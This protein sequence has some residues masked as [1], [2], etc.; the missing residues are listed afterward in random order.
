MGLEARV[1]RRRGGDLEAEV[2]GVRCLVVREEP[3][4]GETI[5]GRQR[6]R[7]ILPIVVDIWNAAPHNRIPV[8]SK[9][10]PH[11]T[12][13]VKRMLLHT[14]HSMPGTAKVFLPFVVGE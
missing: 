8:T 5:V 14:T 6:G 10:V 4:D 1:E 11:S 2:E 12:I 13:L 7:Q 9:T 3:G